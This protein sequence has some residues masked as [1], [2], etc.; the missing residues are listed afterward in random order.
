ML[1]RDVFPEFA[2]K[3]SG[4]LTTFVPAVGSPLLCFFGGILSPCQHNNTISVPTKTSAQSE[5]MLLEVLQADCSGAP[6][7]R[8]CSW[9]TPSLRSSHRMFFLRKLRSCMYFACK[10]RSPQRLY[11]RSQV[12]VI[13]CRK[14]ARIVVRK[15]RSSDRISFCSSF[16]RHTVFAQSDHAYHVG[17]ACIV[18]DML[19]KISPYFLPGGWSL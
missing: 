12:A 14:Y 1:V 13:F 2:S 18:I 5:C 7:P 6:P 10:L 17:W 3:Q 8:R 19:R 16:C 4:R 15:L 11:L 9:T